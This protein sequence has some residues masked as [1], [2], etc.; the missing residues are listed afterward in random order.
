MKCCIICKIE[1]SVNDFHKD[2]SRSDGLNPRCKE[3]KKEINAQYRNNNKDMINEKQKV[4][5]QDNSDRIKKRSNEWYLNNT[6]LHNERMKQYFQ[7]NKKKIK[8]KQEEWNIK[9]KQ[10]MKDY[11]NNYIKNKYHNDLHFKIKSLLSSRIRS[12]ID[13]ERKSF[14]EFLGCTTDFF[15][16]WIEFQ[17]N[18]YMNWE[19]HGEYWHFDHVQP[20]ASFDLTIQDEIYKCF[21]WKN[22]RPL[23]ATENIIKKDKY[24]EEII[25]LHNTIVETFLT[26]CTKE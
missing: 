25:Y 12:C 2:K 22:I 21:S 10:K 4:Y 9:N 17:F 20:C 1:K 7:D 18:E 13:K 23:N 8:E 3:C 15:K 6:S 26:R 19:N 11:M 24:D 16:K 14:S 5:Y